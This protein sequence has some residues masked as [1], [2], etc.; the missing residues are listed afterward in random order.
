[1]SKCQ[2]CANKTGY[3][4]NNKID[5][6]VHGKTKLTVVNCDEYVKVKHKK[7]SDLLSWCD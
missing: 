3:F 1:M 7:R 6:K 2:T 4:Q 5:C